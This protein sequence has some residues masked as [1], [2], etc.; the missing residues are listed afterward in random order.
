MTTARPTVG[1]MG[2]EA[3]MVLRGS[4]LTHQFLRARLTLLIAATLV[5]D[6]VGTVLMYWFEAGAKGSDFDDLGGALFWVT[7]QL[8]TV[9]SQM[10][11]PV[12]TPGRILDIFLE[13]W[14]ISIV[15]TAAAS[16]AAFFHARHLEGHAM[17]PDG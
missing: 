17:P 4:T 10:Q 3:R 9:S 2:K 5:V 12:T 7:A 6:A 1:H 8:T 15:A 14:S 16:L 11:N 13:V